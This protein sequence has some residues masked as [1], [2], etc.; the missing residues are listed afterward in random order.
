M[1]N[2]EQIGIFAMIDE[3]LNL[4]SDWIRLEDVWDKL[5]FQFGKVDL[6]MLE[7]T[8]KDLVELGVLETKDE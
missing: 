6:K 3:L 7:D 2:I 4:S 5:N 1:L 8:V